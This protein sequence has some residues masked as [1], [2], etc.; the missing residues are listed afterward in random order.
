[1]HPPIDGDCGLEFQPLERLFF[2][3]IL[4]IRTIK[5]SLIRLFWTKKTLFIETGSA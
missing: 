5:S 4:T 3:L 1:L 2:V